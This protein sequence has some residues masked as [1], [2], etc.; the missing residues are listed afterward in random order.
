M[1]AVS[2]AAAGKRAT[3]LNGLSQEIAETQVRAG[4]LFSANQF[5]TD[6]LDARI[7]AL[8]ARGRPPGDGTVT[9]YDATQ[10][11]LRVLELCLDSSAQLHHR[12]GASLSVGAAKDAAA[13]L[14]D[15]VLGV[16]DS[17]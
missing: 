6:R 7:D 14:S 2:K 15:W 1:A 17:A 5:E 4:R 12:P 16:V 9:T 8:E 11:R 10:V 3:F 13:L